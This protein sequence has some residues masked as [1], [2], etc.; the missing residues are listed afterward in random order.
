MLLF[1]VETK[2][3]IYRIRPKVFVWM[4]YVCEHTKKNNYY[5]MFYSFVEQNNKAKVC[6]TWYALSKN[7]NKPLDL[8]IC[9]ICSHCSSVGSIPVGLC[10]QACNTTRAPDG[11]APRSSSMPIYK[12]KSL[13]K[14]MIGRTL[15]VVSMDVKKI[16]LR[17]R[18]LRYADHSNGNTLPTNPP[19][20]K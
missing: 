8:T 15:N 9:R 10:A 3:L 19:R 2:S 14:V 11:A 7:G 16:N 17:S 4:S 6:L 13:L 18:V 20:W 1:I 5:R 12:M